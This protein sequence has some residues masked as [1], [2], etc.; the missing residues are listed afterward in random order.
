MTNRRT[1]ITNGLS[2]LSLAMLGGTASFAQS[3]TAA[4][5]IFVFIL[6]RGAMDGLAAIVPYADPNYAGARGS[7]AIAG[8]G[9]PQ[10][11]LPLTEGFG[12]HPKLTGLHALWRAKQLSFMHAAAS[13][14]RDRSHFDGQDVL[15]SG[16]SRL[17]GNETGWL[18]RALALLPAGPQREGVA[19]GRTIPLV[20]RGSSK[21]TSWA[22]PLAP[23]SDTDTL[24]RLMDL[25][26]YDPLLGPAL[27]MAIETDKIADQSNMTAG[28]TGRGGVGG[29]APLASAAARILSAPGGPAAAVLSFEGWDTHA[30]QGG[31]E[32]SLANRLASLDAAIDALKT[33]LG[34]KWD[35][36]TVVVATEFG[37]TV[38]VNGT[39]GT[40]HGTGGAAMI[41][42]GGYAGGRMLGDWPGLARL[43]Q[44][45]DLTPAND[46]RALFTAGLA[47]AWRLNPDVIKARV[48]PT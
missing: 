48:F 22:P 18:N 43:Y 39:G 11:A 38:R 41:L 40:D 12:L 16:A 8:P 24:N 23:E 29:Y 44:D 9:G 13:P 45:R 1:L 33:G 21:A 37:R 14:Y 47:S 31:A 19:I 36:T 42:G 4:P 30:Q 3:G 28:N 5:G 15:E 20:L 32:G 2:G 27:T 46:V 34:P 26:A 25:Y 17:F 7:L 10:G 6:L 35:Q